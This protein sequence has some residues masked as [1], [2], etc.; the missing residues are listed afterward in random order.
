MIESK[1]IPM[2]KITCG[3]P[4][5]QEVL[6]LEG[7]GHSFPGAYP[8]KK[9]SEQGWVRGYYRCIATH[10]HKVYVGNAVFCPKHSKEY[11]K[12]LQDVKDW[13]QRQHNKRKSWWLT[14]F[15][16]ILGKPPINDDPPELNW[17]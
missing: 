9:A 14:C 11:L 3:T 7:K 1:F 16:K 6:L 5:C 8:D 15:D 12:Y 17:E 13:D 4:G 10:T 2:W